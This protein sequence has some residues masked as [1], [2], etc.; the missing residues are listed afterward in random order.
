MW[1]SGWGSGWGG[2]WAALANIGGETEQRRPLHEACFWSSASERVR[3]GL[4]GAD[5]GLWGEREEGHCDVMRRRTTTTTSHWLP[6][7]VDICLVC[8]RCI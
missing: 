6:A 2:S 5:G 4:A 7:V 3:P 8:L 1:G